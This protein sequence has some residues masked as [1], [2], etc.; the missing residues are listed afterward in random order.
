MAR[1]VKSILLVEPEG[2]LAEVTAF[3]LE[4]LGYRVE[5]VSSAEE[6]LK[7]ISTMTPDLVITDLVLG[8]ADATG[9]IECLSSREETNDIP[10][11]VLSMDADLD[12]VTTAYKVGAADFLVVPY[13]PEVLQEK[14]VKLLA[15]PRRQ[16][17]EKNRVLAEC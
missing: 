7:W 11:M 15:R 4:L 6:A 8:G 12:R 13:Q 17:D 16:T 5:I 2:V 14:V 9:L 10:V 3:R 1:I